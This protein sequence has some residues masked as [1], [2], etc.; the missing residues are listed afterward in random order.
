MEECVRKQAHNSGMEGTF[1][2][3]SNM[4]F[5]LWSQILCINFKWFA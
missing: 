3:K 5:H 2:L 1:K 4:T